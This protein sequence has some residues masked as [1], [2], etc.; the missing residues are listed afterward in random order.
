MT[1][2]QGSGCMEAVSASVKK[3]APTLIADPYFASRLAYLVTSSYPR[4]SMAATGA[5]DDAH[6]WQ[7]VRL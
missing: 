2:I 5:M 7:N 3:Q 6:T 1:A 4:R